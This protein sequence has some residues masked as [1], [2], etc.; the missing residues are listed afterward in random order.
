M[1]NYGKLS[2]PLSLYHSARENP[3][4][5]FYQLCLLAVAAIVLAGIFGF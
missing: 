3:R 2:L 1:Q 5:F 4:E